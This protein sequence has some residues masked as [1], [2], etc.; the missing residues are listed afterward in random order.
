MC[1]H[2]HCFERT[3]SQPYNVPGIVNV[4]GQVDRNVYLAQPL[5]SRSISSKIIQLNHAARGIVCIVQAEMGKVSPQLRGRFPL[6]AS[7]TIDRIM[8]RNNGGR[9]CSVERAIGG[10]PCTQSRDP[11]KHAAAQVPSPG[12]VIARS[13][14]LFHGFGRARACTGPA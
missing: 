1:T 12:K 2:S 5:T 14:A 10:S 11:C 13:R 9:I 4:N 6:P 8:T 3:P 7:I